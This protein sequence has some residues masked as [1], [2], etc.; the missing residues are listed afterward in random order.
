[1]QKQR[2]VLTLQAGLLLTAVSLMV[3]PFLSSRVSVSMS[4]P[5]QAEERAEAAAR[6]KFKEPYVMS[7]T[8]KVQVTDSRGKAQAPKRGQL[9]R[10]KAVFETGPQSLVQVALSKNERLFVGPQS[11]VSIPVISWEDGSME[12]LELEK[13]SMRLL[14]LTS[15]PRLVVT[16]VSRDTYSEADLLFEVDP[17]A[18]RLRVAV[19]DG[20]T[21]FRGLENEEFTPL[22]RGEEATFQGVIEGGE[23]VFDVLLQGRKVAR[24]KVEPKKKST[25]TPA[26]MWWTEAEKIAQKDKAADVARVKEKARAGAICQKPSARL[27]ECAWV[28]EN[29]PKKEKKACRL[30]LANVRCVRMKCDANGEWSDRLEITPSKSPCGVQPLVAA[31]DY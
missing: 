9:L 6:T 27:N 21:A 13:G 1:M 15:A 25:L 29:N 5:A 11:R 20:R 18:A 16:P 28:C 19:L 31:C 14:N 24:G 23:I 8:G 2:L 3:A 10:E 4:A 7:F 17:S 26:Q 12:R 30:E 22:E